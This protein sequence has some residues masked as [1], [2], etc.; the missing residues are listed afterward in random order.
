MGSLIIIRAWV[1]VEK[2]GVLVD[3]GVCELGVD[4]EVVVPWMGVPLQVVWCSRVVWYGALSTGASCGERS[5][6]PEVAVQ[7]AEERAEPRESN[8]HEEGP[9]CLGW[10]LHL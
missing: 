5:R 3:P 6:K 8:V 10:T 4:T 9:G 7:K 2:A 1:G